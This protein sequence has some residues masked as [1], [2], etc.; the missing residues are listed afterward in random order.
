MRGLKTAGKIISKVMVILLALLVV[1]NFYTVVMQQA[2]G[3]KQTSVFGFSSAVVISG[4][5][6]P[7]IHVDDMVIIRKQ[8]SYELRDIVMY[9]SGQSMVTHRIVGLEDGAYITRGDNNNTDDPTVSEERIAG[10]VVCIIPGAGKVISF[11]Q[12][13]LGMCILVLLAAAMLILPDLRNKEK[14]ARRAKNS[15]E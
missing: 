9:E 11:I 12:S 13:P 14:K 2:L 10:K 7:A 8:K 1:L 4:S 3:R 15:D 6:E 5:M